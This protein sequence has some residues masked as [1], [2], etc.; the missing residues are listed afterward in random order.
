MPAEGSGNE[1]VNEQRE[2]KCE[3]GD[4][5]RENEERGYNLKCK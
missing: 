3:K 4:F 5:Q 2:G 1:W